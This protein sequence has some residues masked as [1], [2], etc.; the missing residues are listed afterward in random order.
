LTETGE[1]LTYKSKNQMNFFCHISD[2]VDFPCESGG[3]TIFNY[4]KLSFTE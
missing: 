3:L 4:F 1:H 2:L